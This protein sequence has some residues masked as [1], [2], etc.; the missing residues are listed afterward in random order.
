MAGGLMRLRG[1]ARA[2]TRCKCGG[3]ERCGRRR[4]SLLDVGHVH[5]DDRD[6]EDGEG[7]ADT[8]AVVSP[9]AGVD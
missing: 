4:Q 7:V 3:R 9:G 2:R 1:G 5:L 6:V 8:V